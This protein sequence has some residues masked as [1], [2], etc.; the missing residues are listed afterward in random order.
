M[1]PSDDYDS[2][3]TEQVHLVDCM[4]GVPYQTFVAEGQMSDRGEADF[5]AESGEEDMLVDKN[6]SIASSTFW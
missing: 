2:E 1:V 3:S 4:Q 6:I 5:S